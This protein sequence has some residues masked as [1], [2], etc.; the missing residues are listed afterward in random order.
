MSKFTY[1]E[2]FGGIL[3]FGTA[4]DQLGGNCVF[5]SEI[6]P[7]AQKAIQ[8]LGKGD[9]L[10]GDITQ[11]KSEDVPQHDILT[12]GFPCPS[13]SVAGKRGGMEYECTDCSHS[14]LIT[15]EEYVNSAKC[16]ECGGHTEPKDIRGLLFFEVARI[17]KDKQPK[18]VLLENVKGLTSSGDGEVMRIITETLNDIGFTIDFTLLNSKYFDV[19]QS[20]ERVFITA[21]RDD[22][23]GTE[24]W[25]ALVGTTVI[26]KAKRKLSSI[27]GVKSFNFD[28]PEQTEVRTRLRDFLEESV[29][30]KYYLSEDKT[31][32][33][34][35]QSCIKK[36]LRQVGYVEKNMQGSR[37]YDDAGV[38]ATVASQT[39]G[40]GGKGVTLFMEQK[41]VEEVR[42][43][44][45]PF[46]E[47]KR[48]NGPRFKDDGAEAHTITTIDRHGVAIGEYP[49]YRIRKLTPTEC[50]KLQSV[51]SDT[52][53]TL[54][55]NFSDSRL[56]K[57]AGNGLTT[58][59]IRAIGERLLTYL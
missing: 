58:N 52:I 25:E 54:K 7:F 2:I 17:A 39:G 38:G 51:P 15:F 21:L 22:L 27:D 40:L 3:G 43:C 33:L 36:D 20:R 18:A 31:A 8:A 49:R 32:K 59:V 46:R 45:T 28:W 24:S 53:V 48:Q 42:P 41:I 34:V 50:L 12:V 14:H 4:F 16:P 56:Y 47:E 6:D 9:V 11:V 29:D 30:E 1:A 19:A 55:A 23:V 57:F 10:N 37:V 26:P 44:L 13:F 5:I 35:T